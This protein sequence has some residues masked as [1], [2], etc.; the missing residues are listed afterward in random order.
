MDILKAT[1]RHG[2]KRK[3]ANA[4]FEASTQTVDAAVFDR[5]SVE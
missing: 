4:K 1:A 3:P 2:G 5:L